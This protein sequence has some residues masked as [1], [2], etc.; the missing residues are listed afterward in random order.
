MLEVRDREEAMHPAHRPA[1]V[2][3]VPLEFIPGI[4][5][6]TLSKLLDAFGTEMTVLHQAKVSELAQVVGDIL[7]KRIDDAR[8]G[9]IHVIDGGGGI[10]GKIAPGV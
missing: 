8:T 2:Y 10:Y 3:Q 1:Y 9:R 7:A 6:K 5:K 4:G